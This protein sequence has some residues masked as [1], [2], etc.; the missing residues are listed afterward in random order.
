MVLGGKEATPDHNWAR[1]RKLG[2]QQLRDP[3]GN[4]KIASRCPIGLS[5]SWTGVAN[6]RLGSARGGAREENVSDGKIG[7][8]ESITEM[9]K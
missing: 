8:E 4:D 2:L 9:H 5:Q 7:G 1:H 6:D 3:R